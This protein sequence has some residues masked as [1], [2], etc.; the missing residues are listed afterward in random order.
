MWKPGKEIR[1]SWKNIQKQQQFT[2]YKRRR[3]RRRQRSTTVRMHIMHFL[4]LTTRI[5][6]HNFLNLR[7]LKWKSRRKKNC[8]SRFYEPRKYHLMFWDQY[9]SHYVPIFTYIGYF[10]LFFFLV[11]NFFRYRSTWVFSFTHDTII[12]VEECALILEWQDS[13]LFSC[14]FFGV[15]DMIVFG[16][17][18]CMRKVCE[19]VPFS[20]FLDF[21]P[22]SKDLW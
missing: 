3:E 18:L 10:A 21:N 5:S 22:C 7:K 8:V 19:N 2:L 11:G 12:K 9:V 16:M 17:G 20:V 6:S 1:I 13:L 15:W 14:G 4:H